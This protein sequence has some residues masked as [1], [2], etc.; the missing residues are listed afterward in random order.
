VASNGTIHA[1]AKEC[2]YGEEH[3]RYALRSKDGVALTTPWPSHS[4]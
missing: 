4:T 2:P 3:T 1:S